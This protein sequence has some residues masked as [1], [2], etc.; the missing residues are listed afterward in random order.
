[1]A[2]SERVHEAIREVYAYAGHVDEWLVIKK[3]L[4]KSLPAEERKSF[5]TRDPLTK[6]QKANSF[7]HEVAD[8]WQELTGRPVI[9]KDY[10]KKA[11]E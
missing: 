2:I 8:I 5:S 11:A 7:E 3:E 6:Q 10:E 4:L 9:F 1:M